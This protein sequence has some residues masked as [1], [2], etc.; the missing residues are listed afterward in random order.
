MKRNDIYL[1]LKNIMNYLRNG[2]IDEAEVKLSKLIN[3]VNIDRHEKYDSYEMLED[4]DEQFKRMENE[5]KILRENLEFM[6]DPKKL[7]KSWYK[8]DEEK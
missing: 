7:Q 4:L 2:N 6:K 5:L 3:N 8:H 1:T